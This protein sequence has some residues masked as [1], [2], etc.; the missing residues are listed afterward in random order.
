MANPYGKA[1]KIDPRS[2]LD[3]RAY[4]VYGDDPRLPGWTWYV[5]KM[6]QAPANAAKNP[7]AS[8][9]CL[10]TTPM[11]GPY[12]DLGDTYLSDIGGRLLHGVDV[13]GND[14]KPVDF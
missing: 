4:A 6:N 3:E 1:V 10:V 13:R 8:A 12:G 9:F 11:S 14:R 7:Y 2:T 5:L